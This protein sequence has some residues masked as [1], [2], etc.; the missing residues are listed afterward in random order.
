MNI[1]RFKFLSLLMLV[2][3]LTTAVSCSD[4]EPP[5]PDNQA[6]FSA[7]ELGFSDE[8]S[9]ATITINLT[10]AADEDKNLT[11]SFVPTG[12]TYG[13]EFTTTPVATANSFTLTIPAGATE[14][15]FKVTK[16]EGIF[17]EGDE[18]I[19][20]TIQSVEEPFVLKDAITVKLS[21]SQIVSEGGALQLQGLIAAEA[22]S[23]A[24]NAVFVDFSANLQ[25]P[26]ARNSWDLGFHAGDDYR[27]ILNN[28][29]AA[30]AKMVNKTDMNAV[31]S[32]DVTANDLA[33]GF[34]SGSFSAYDS[35]NGDLEYTAI[36][37]VSA[38]D[39]EN[40]VWVINRAGGS[41]AAQASTEWY[42]IR[43]LRNGTG[44]TL[45]YAQ[46]NATVFNTITIE[47]NHSLNF[48]YFHFVNGVV[49]IEP[50]KTNWDIQWGWSIYYT[51]LDGEN[52]PY[53]FS[54]LVFINHHNGVKAA[55]VLTADVTYDAFAEA[56]LADYDLTSKRDLIG[57]NW[58]V[59]APGGPEAIGVR[60]NR[61]YLVEDS[62]GNVYKLKF[63][64]FHANDGGTRGKPNIAYALVKKA[65]D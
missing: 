8:D 22:G 15:S 17:L 23:S 42:K 25:K 35:I 40:K 32:A 34:A 29:T 45:Q 26:V 5:L 21:F 10:R 59:T 48:S 51:S 65:D 18:S 58:R 1:T 63:V 3:L 54:D 33:I 30:S 20:F 12:V 52:V 39:A 19:L 37:E 27:V 46:V 28:F 55:E 62:Q 7:S 16:A 14:A 43:V 4:D 60:T 57:S 64:N 24:G 41:G 50:A 61:F 9:E 31:T 6:S 47:K 53:A 44:Y 11:V 38:T 36:S 49:S 2:I 13:T 56:D